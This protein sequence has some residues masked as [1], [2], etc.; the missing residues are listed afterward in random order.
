MPTSLIDADSFLAIDIGTVSTR[1]MLFDVVDGRYR[2]IASGSAATTAGAPYADVGEG[3]RQAVDQ[4]Q[5]IT[6]RSLIDTDGHMIIPSQ[7]NGAGVDV[8]VG[9][10]SAGKPL[11][12]V[13]VGLLEDVSAESA[14]RLA[15]TTYAQVVDR[16]SLNDRR[17]SHS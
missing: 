17:K 16:F 3:V 4:L 6:G 10:L 14:Q 15:T 11:R 13:S 12:V 1:A 7:D 5:L 8:L 9:T 2:Y